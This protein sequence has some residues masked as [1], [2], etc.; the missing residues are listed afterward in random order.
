M[1]YITLFCKGIMVG[2][3]NVIPGVSGGTIAVVLRIFDRLLNAINHFFSDIKK[4]LRF[5]IPLGLGAV[6][7]ILAFSVLIEYCL[8]RFSLPTCGFFAGLVA[9]SVPLLFNIARSKQDRT[10][11]PFVY[12]AATLVAFAAVVLLAL[13]KAPEAVASEAINSPALLTKVFFGGILAAAAM[14]IP[15]VSGSFIMVLLGL[16]PVIIRNIAMLKD[17]LQTRD[18]S[19]LVQVIVFLIPLGLGVLLGIILIARVIGFL[20]ERFHTLTY[21]LILGLI[22]GSIF[23][24][25]IDP[26]TYASYPSVIPTSAIIFAIITFGAGTGLALLLGKE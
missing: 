2:I 19:I 20:T 24:I 3:A 14:V 22:F 6:V 12:Y 17:F 1:E 10:K 8:E 18:V 25:F 13:Q 5:L 16:Y 15:G 7:G 9:G 23:G 21:Y 4:H 26:L 11:S